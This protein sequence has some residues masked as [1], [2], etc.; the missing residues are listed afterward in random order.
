MR[1][2]EIAPRVVILST[3]DFHSDVWTNKQHLAVGL[4][5]LGVEVVY[6]ESLGLRRPTISLSD[7]R[8]AV[9]KLRRKP[10]TREQPR[11]GRSQP[12]G[13]KIVTPRVV[14]FHA[15]RLVRALNRRLIERY[16]S[17]RLRS[18]TP[19]LL[20]TF[21]PITYGLQ[22]HCI[23]TV[24]HSVDLLHS[25][26]G[27]P[28]RTVLD[29]ERKLLGQAD[30]VVASS[31]GV[32]NHL[33]SVNDREVLLWENVAHVT[34][35]RPNGETRIDRA[36]FAGNLTPTKV[37]IPLLLAIADSGMSLALAGPTAIDGTVGGNMLQQ[38]L[39]HKNVEYLGNLSLDELAVEVKTSTVGLIPYLINDYTDGVFP[40]KVYEYLAAGLDVVATQI[41]SLN[42]SRER[43]VRVVEREDFVDTV[44]SATDAFSE[45]EARQRSDAAQEHSWENRARAAYLL[46][47]ELLE[48]NA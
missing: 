15:S 4:A 36:I 19:A 9:R 13:L 16:V 14:P 44:K 43:G 25:V 31:T 22:E 24:Y 23:A 18:D 27:V 41:P 38:L 35:F 42:N 2:T 37:D 48:L 1:A 46:I 3:A 33:A 8:R 6:V 30:R 32:R 10:A 21:S 47:S 17:P 7:A 11:S 26:P 12:E 39:E 29:S 45:N 20:W 28:S 40:M 5:E 34:R